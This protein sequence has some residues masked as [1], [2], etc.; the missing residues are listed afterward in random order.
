MSYT[1]T[2]SSKQCFIVRQALSGA[3]SK[4]KRSA[5]SVTAR[6]CSQSRVVLDSAYNNSMYVI[7]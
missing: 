3:Y 4:I 5:P 7:I 1:G 2:L 6:S